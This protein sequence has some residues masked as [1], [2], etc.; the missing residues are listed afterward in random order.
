MAVPFGIATAATIRV[1][2]VR[3]ALRLFPEKYRLY[4]EAREAHSALHGWSFSK[5]AFLA[6]LR[7]AVES[8][9]KFALS[10]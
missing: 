4:L 5:E 8:S 1:G 7:D 9:F 10:K 6:F 3:T 2:N